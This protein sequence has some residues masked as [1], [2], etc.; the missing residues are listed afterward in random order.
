LACP[1]ADFP[2]GLARWELL[3]FDFDDMKGEINRQIC[4][5]NNRFIDYVLVTVLKY[6]LGTA[7]RNG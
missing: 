3:F 6:T 5:T 2:L 4:S 1:A 7:A